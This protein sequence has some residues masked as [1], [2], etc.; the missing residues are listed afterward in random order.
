MNSLLLDESPLI[1]LPSLAKLIGLNES[2]F[3]QQIHYWLIKNQRENRNFKSERYWTYNTLEEWQE[4]FPFWSTRT[5]RRIVSS[6][7][8]RK[9]LLHEKMADNNWDRTN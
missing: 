1:V 3:L 5:I 2:I 9:I 7:V 8:D 4:V 6:L